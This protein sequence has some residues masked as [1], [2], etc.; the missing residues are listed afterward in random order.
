[1]AW[2]TVA[3]ILV[4]AGLGALLGYMGKCAGGGG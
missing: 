4:G 1:M 2:K 3:G